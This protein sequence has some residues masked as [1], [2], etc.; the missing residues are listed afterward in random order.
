MKNITTQEIADQLN[1]TGYNYFGDNARAYGDTIQFGRGFVR[2]ENGKLSNNR[3][4]KARALT[5]GW[6]AVQA[7]ENA[8][9]EIK[10]RMEAEAAAKAAVPQHPI[11][12]AKAVG[13]ANIGQCPRSVGAM[14]DYVPAAVITKSSSSDLAELLDAMW[15]ACQDAKSIAESHLA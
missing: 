7:C 9:N 12:V 14:L 15:I 6:P 2:Y 3:Q 13:S 4:G 8:V 5:I 11:K 10:A 1:A